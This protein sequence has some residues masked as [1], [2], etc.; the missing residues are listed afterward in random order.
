MLSQKHIIKLA[1]IAI[2]L[3]G[4]V[5]VLNA[6]YYKPDF[7]PIGLTGLNYTGWDPSRNNCPYGN[8]NVFPPWSWD[9]DTNSEKQLIFSLGVNCIGSEDAYPPYLMDLSLNDGTNNYLHKICMQPSGSDTVF[10]ITANYYT[11]K[12][13][14]LY[15]STPCDTIPDSIDTATSPGWQRPSNIFRSDSRVGG[16]WGSEKFNMNSCYGVKYDNWYDCDG[17][18]LWRVMI[19]EAVDRYVAFADSH[20]TNMDCIW[21]YNI[22]SEDPAFSR[23]NELTPVW[24]GCWAAV[25][26][27]FTG[28]KNTSWFKGKPGMHTPNHSGIRGAE[29]DVG[30]DHR[31]FMAKC[32]TYPLHKSNYNIFQYLPDLDVIVNYLHC[33][34][35]ADWNYGDQK[36]FERLLYDYHS[37][38]SEQYM[39]YHNTAIYM[40][41]Y[42]NT[43]GGPVGQKRRWI[44]AF[45]LEWR[46]DETYEEDS[47]YTRRPCPPEIR[48]ATYLSLSRGAK[49][50]LWHPWLSNYEQHE[51]F[52][53]ESDEIKIP[54]DKRP[55]WSKGICVGLRDMQGYPFGHS[56]GG[57][58]Y[59]NNGSGS[60]HWH[61]I[62]DPDARKDITYIYLKNDLIPEIKAISA[63]LIELDWING[64][65]LNSTCP[66]WRSPC[67][68]YYVEDVWGVEYADLGFF[69]HPYEPVGVEYFMMVN[70]EGIADMTNREVGV[71]LDAEHW[72]EEDTLILTDI[73]NADNPRRLTRVGERFT[74]TE[75][76]EPGEGK[77]YRVAPTNEASITLVPSTEG[78]VR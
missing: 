17:D 62:T 64:Y 25:D 2:V 49:G 9:G 21:G 32:E 55:G 19:D 63:K 71:A 42:G 77:L 10:L 70:R 6:T 31:M 47:V 14:Y 28:H 7:F 59:L 33:W 51:G 41:Q 75:F 60:T 76:F 58:H 53:F 24:H 74:F 54:Q 13:R 20:S 15:N 4:S 30:M 36:I 18:S 52:T 16:A 39:G 37:P 46:M 69:D 66:E 72:P 5:A 35:Y 57:T 61:G 38:S 11:T 45:T 27:V 50:I 78:G 67:P 68:H 73:A 65:S 56:G 8:A 22:I 12:R 23:H 26:Y 3:G 40:Q 34:C 48:C 1:I 44:A 29:D 43:P